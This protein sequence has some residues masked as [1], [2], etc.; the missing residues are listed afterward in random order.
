M[1]K[2]FISESVVT[3]KSFKCTIFILCFWVVRFKFNLKNKQTMQT[4]HK[5]ENH[6]SSAEEWTLLFWF[7]ILTEK[8]SNIKSDLNSQSQMVNNNKN[9]QNNGI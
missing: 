2:N 4:I 6:F 3:W 1:H 7:V 8:N 9:I 5:I